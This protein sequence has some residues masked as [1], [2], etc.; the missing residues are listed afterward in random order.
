MQHIPSEIEIELGLDEADDAETLRRKAARKAG[1]DVSALPELALRKRSIDARR[2]RVVFR[3]LLEVD[4]EP[5]DLG[6]PH[7]RDVDRLAR[8]V[9]IGDGPAGLFC[10]Y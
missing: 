9:I 5:L 1:V 2:G 8:V 7:P 6:A 10:A 3:L 4:P